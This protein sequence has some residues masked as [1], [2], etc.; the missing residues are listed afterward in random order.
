VVPTRIVV[1]G[2]RKTGSP[3]LADEGARSGADLPE[4]DYREL[5]CLGALD[6]LMALREL[7]EGA[8]VVLGVGCYVSRC[9]HISGSQRAKVAFERLQGILEE[10]G[11]DGSRVGLVLGSPIDP[12]GIF[13]A[14]KEF[15]SSEGGDGK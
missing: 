6:P 7:N 1:F 12:A 9:E 10:V 13:D 14:I 5:P 4:M 11:I 15:I 3:V 2:C 8:D